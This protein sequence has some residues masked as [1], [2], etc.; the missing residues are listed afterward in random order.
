VKSAGEDLTESQREK[1]VSLSKGVDFTDEADFEEK[2]AEIKEAYFGV[3]SETIA[4]ET[5][6]EE[7]NG[8]FDTEVEKVLDPSIAR[9]SEALTKLKPLG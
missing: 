3:D 6:Q 8:D 7:G 9:Y 5:V 1:L 4:E 2:I